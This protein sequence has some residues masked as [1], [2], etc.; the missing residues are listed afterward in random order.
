MRSTLIWSLTCLGL[1]G[2][3][4][5]Q[6]DDMI[7]EDSYF[8]GQVPATFPSPQISE[9]GEWSDSVTRAKDLVAQMTLEET[10]RQ[11]SETVMQMPTA[12]IMRA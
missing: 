2:L 10:R 8:Y 5:S 9:D 11:L 7:T 6:D 1:S 12:L 4:A 3:A